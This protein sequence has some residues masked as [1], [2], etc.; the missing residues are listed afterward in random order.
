MQRQNLLDNIGATV[1]IQRKEFAINIPYY[2]NISVMDTVTV[3]SP[4]IIPDDAF[5]W[6]ISNW[7]EKKWRKS[8]QA[9][10]IVNNANWLVR[11]VKHNNY[12][13]QLIVQE[14]I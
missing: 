11:S 2:M 5:I 1:K 4:Q 14:I 12:K 6:G 10:N 13:T 8:L 7:G 3:T 9:D